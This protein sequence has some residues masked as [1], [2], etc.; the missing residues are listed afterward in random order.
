M[1][2]QSVNSPTVIRIK[3]IINNLA[4]IKLVKDIEEITTEEGAQYQ[5]E[6]VTIKLHDRKNLEQYCVDNFEELFAVGM[7]EEYAPKLARAYTY[8]TDTDWVCAKCFEL[9][10]AVDV[11]YPDEF[12]KR[13]EAREFINT[14]GR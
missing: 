6:E 9:G 2:S 10:I 3:N 4:T 8:L 12:A 14:W 5:Y 13:A 7:K 1:K 11:K